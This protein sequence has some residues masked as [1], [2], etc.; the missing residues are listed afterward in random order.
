VAVPTY[1]E[2]QQQAHSFD[3]MA[4]YNWDG[5][6]LTGDGTPEK[7]QDFL[8]TT[9]FF[10]TLGVQPHLGRIFLPEEGQPGQN[11]RLIL[12]YGLW[13]AATL[14]IQTSLAK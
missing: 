2:W 10:S 8:V 4:A 9:N 12:S 7:V 13:N 3:Q 14:P 6:N 11:Q 5:V 1:L